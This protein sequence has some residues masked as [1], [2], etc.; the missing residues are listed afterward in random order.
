MMRAMQWGEEDDEDEFEWKEEDEDE[1]PAGAGSSLA[2]INRVATVVFL[3]LLGFGV[4][5][6]IVRVAGALGRYFG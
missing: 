1:L 3:G 6:V 4:I 5:Y 2:K